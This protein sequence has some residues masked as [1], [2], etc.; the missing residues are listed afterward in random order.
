MR[1]RTPI[2]LD[3]NGR[4]FALTA[5]QAADLQ[6]TLAAVIHRQRSEKQ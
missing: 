4:K 3:F 6:L 5:E 2:V 1:A